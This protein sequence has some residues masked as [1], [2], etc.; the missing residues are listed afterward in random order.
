[1]L[2]VKTESR[3]VQDP[4]ERMAVSIFCFI[5]TLTWRESQWLLYRIFLPMLH[6]LNGFPINTR[7]NSSFIQEEP[8]T[9]LLLPPV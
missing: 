6:L 1:M 8:P 5:R 2:H 4:A 7:D 9:L 3:K